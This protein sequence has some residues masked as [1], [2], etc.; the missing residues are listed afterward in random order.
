MAEVVRVL[1][2]HQFRRLVLTLLHRLRAASV[3]AH[4]LWANGCGWLGRGWTSRTVRVASSY[5]EAS[6]KARASARRDAL[7]SGDRS[8]Q[9]TWSTGAATTRTGHSLFP[10][11]S[12]TRAVSALESY[13][14]RRSYPFALARGQR[15]RSS[16]A[17]AKLDAIELHHVGGAGRNA[18]SGTTSSGA[19]MPR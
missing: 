19:S 17:R 11:E 9:K 16:S 15:S 1:R 6:S 14:A 4:A 13:R 3:L 12:E 2:H 7:S 18:S 10:S 5:C 8:S